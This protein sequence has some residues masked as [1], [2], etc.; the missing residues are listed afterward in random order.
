MRYPSLISW[1][2]DPVVWLSVV[3]ESLTIMLVAVDTLVVIR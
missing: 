2:D 1:L 3:L